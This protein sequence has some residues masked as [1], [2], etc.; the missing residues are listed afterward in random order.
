MT[1]LKNKVIGSFIGLAVGDALGASVEFMP[2][3]T[4]QTVTDMQPGGPFN[5][6]I[7]EWT[8]DTIMALCLAESLIKNS[9]FNEIDILNSWLAWY[10]RGYN[11]PKGYCFDI[12]STTAGS[13]KYYSFVRSP[14]PGLNQYA[15][16]N[17]SIMRLSPIPAF[18]Y[19]NKEQALEL[20]WKQG[21]LTHNSI[22]ANDCCYILASYILRAYEN[23]DV[24]SNIDN[25]NLHHTVK[26]IAFGQYKNKTIDQI[27]SGGYC[28]ETLEAAIWSV[29][30]TNNFSD[31][32]LKAVNLG[33]DT[34]SVAAVAG[35]IA[36]AIYGIDNIPNNWID[37]L[38]RK[39]YLLEVGEKLYEQRKK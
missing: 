27:K 11:S 18:Y 30:T 26:H 20:S 36:G 3:G 31:A 35:Q 23:S 24:F 10:E 8:D 33:D 7:G 34:D 6:K 39:D 19:E 1:N 21:N 29:Y 12:G 14:I 4:F 37:K 13:L 9:G 28:V 2:R 32:V 22:I 38:H 25:S 16:G 17:G 15:A 5:L